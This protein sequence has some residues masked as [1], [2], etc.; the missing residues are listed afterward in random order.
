[1]SA[2]PDRWRWFATSRLG[3]FIHWGP[4]A[5]H[6]RGEQVLIRELMDQDAY[7][8][9]ACAWRPSAFDPRAWA[10]TARQ[11][12]FRYAV[13]T[14]RH[15]DGFCMWDSALTDYGLARQG[16]G[17]DAVAAYA[18]A[19]RAE[20]LRV[21]LYYSLADWRIPA[22]F[23]GPARDPVGWS[24]F[25]A[26]IHGQVEELLTRYGPICEFWFDGAWP[27][28]AAAWD[29]EGL[30]A[31]MRRL[32]PDIMVNNRLD[33]RDPDAP[34][35]PSGQ[36]EAAG[37][38]RVLGDFGTPEHHTTAEAHRPWEACHTTTSRLWGHA[39]GE[40]WRDSAQVLDL[41]TDAAAKGGNL[42]LNVGPDAEGCLPSQ[43]LDLCS[44]LGPW[45]AVHGE[46][47]ADSEPGPEP[48]ESVTW[49]RIIRRGSTMFLVVR[50]WD[51]RGELVLH[52]LG[53]RALAARL[54]GSD[55]VLTL[56]QD[57]DRLVVRGLPVRP[58]GDLFPVI[59]V[60]C[61]G[62]PRPTSRYGPL[63]NGDPMRYHA[64]AS[65]RGSSVWMDG[66]TR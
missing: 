20:G 27:R 35:P 36:I 41:I 22:Y 37:E 56:S 66:R 38:S 18:E 5:L 40:R 8:R 30:L 52:G 33:S 64:W 6:A 10:R 46:C 12:G 3:L 60:D 42:L 54:L 55:A 57:D 59:R 63:W 32:Q 9:A 17:I 14:A 44:R 49:G 25:R 15:H 24:G 47:L 58:P 2:C 65:A 1:M 19:F 31:M 13:L 29:S 7:A 61:D 53:S 50:F 26:Y 28:N 62:A 16:A 48:G 34:P 45:M 11:A 4:Y 21:G 51:G 23:A 43:F 39:A